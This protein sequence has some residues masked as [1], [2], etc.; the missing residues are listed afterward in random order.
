MERWL[1]RRKGGELRA[2]A[3]GGSE[4]VFDETQCKGHFDAHGARLRQALSSRLRRLGV[5]P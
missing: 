4:A 1:L 3:G 2:R 5:E